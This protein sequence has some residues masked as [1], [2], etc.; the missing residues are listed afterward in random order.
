MTTYGALPTRDPELAETSAA[1]S[2]QTQQQERA[3]W[4]HQLGEVLENEKVH[5]A[6]IGLVVLDAVCVLFQIIYT[7]LHECQMDSEPSERI[8]FLVEAADVISQGVTCI[9]LLELVLA[10][11][12]FG[13]RYYLPGWPH[14]KLHILDVIVVVATFVFD[15]V[16]HGKEREVA[17][18]L[19]IFRL[20][21]VVR[22][23]EATVMSVSFAKDEEEQ[24]VNKQL[25]EA[26]LAHDKLASK[27]EQEKQRRMELE[28]EVER[29]KAE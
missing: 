29:L 19:I 26:R 14:W 10:F 28:Q 18:L 21:R 17:E 1:L 4:R 27:L 2:E 3:E 25:E 6:I 5:L 12:A 7:F 23:V 11:I 8:K 13:P 24:D 9:F 22:I 15:I 16:L 20:W